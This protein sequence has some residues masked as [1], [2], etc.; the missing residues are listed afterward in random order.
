MNRRQTLA[1]W[2]TKLT[3]GTELSECQEV[4]KVLGRYVFLCVDGGSVYVNTSEDLEEA[5]SGMIQQSGFDGFD[6]SQEFAWVVLGP[7]DLDE[8]KMA[9]VKV[10]LECTF[11][12]S[13]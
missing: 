7:I 2:V 8:D 6:G 1:K 3:G 4:P 12:I 5:K 11:D 9:T 10:S 13:F